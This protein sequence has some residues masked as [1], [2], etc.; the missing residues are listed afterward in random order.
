MSVYLATP[1]LKCI[2]TESSQ[3]AQTLPAEGRKKLILPIS[4]GI[5]RTY[6]LE[7]MEYL[8]EDLQAVC[9]FTYMH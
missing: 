6:A 7:E 9:N 4:A 3:I 5:L 8:P 1:H 2:L